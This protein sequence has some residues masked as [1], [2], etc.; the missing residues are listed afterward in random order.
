MG[1][2]GEGAEVRSLFQALQTR[3]SPP[4]HIPGGIPS[5]QPL[6]QRGW[7]R[8][9]AG[10]WLGSWWGKLQLR[11]SGATPR[12]WRFQPSALALVKGAAPAS[13]AKHPHLCLV[14]IPRPGA[15]IQHLKATIAK[16]IHCRLILK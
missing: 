7:D 14:Q 11:G 4:P 10:S 16:G 9:C 5:L 6:L 3:G 13:R 2:V 1:Q 8:K 15:P 12:P